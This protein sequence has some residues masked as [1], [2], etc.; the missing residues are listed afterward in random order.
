MPADPP[1]ADECRFYRTTTLELSPAYR[2]CFTDGRLTH[3]D[4]I[5]FDP[6]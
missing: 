3:K 1:G 6:Q 4:R 2:L 5:E